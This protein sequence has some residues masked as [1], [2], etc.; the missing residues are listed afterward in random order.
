MG[1]CVV[2]GA[3]AGKRRW[4]RLRAALRDP[5]VVALVVSVL[6]LSLSAGIYLAGE[7]GRN[8]QV[9]GPLD[10]LEWVVL[11]LLQQSSPWPFSSGLGRTVY[12][13]VLAAGVGLGITGTA[14]VASRLL[15]TYFKKGS[16]MGQAKLSDHIVMCGW[17]SKGAAILR[18][19]HA[20]KL[21]EHTPVVIVA[22]LDGS[23][24]RDPLARFIRGNPVNNEDLLR[25]GVDRAKAAIILAAEM[26]GSPTPD[27]T[28][29]NT[30]LTTLAVEALNP[31]CYTCVE[32]LRAENKVH[33]ERTK[34]DE[35]VVSSELTGALLASSARTHGLSRVVGDLVTAPDGHE[36]YTCDVPPRLAGRSFTEASHWLKAETDCILVAVAPPADRF[37]INPPGDRPLLAGERL[38]L[39][40]GS[41]PLD[42][43]LAAAA[44]VEPAGG[45]GPAV[46]R[47]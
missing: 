2:Q 17:S 11:T 47:P 25:A 37:A 12:F 15:Q 4:L 5:K 46:S 1:G 40:A 16:G 3:R 14:A 29:A 38:L 31:R 22:P 39:I 41:C 13:F 20:D 43:I 23:P 28:D 6:V 8:E 19:L 34:A 33:F 44:G 36:F 26:P 27:E 42:E 30:L 9:R 24:T 35:L 45:G 7:R 32:V 21:S 18:D 10:A